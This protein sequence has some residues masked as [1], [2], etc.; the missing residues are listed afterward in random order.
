MSVS[1]APKPNKA[2]PRGLNFDVEQAAFRRQFRGLLRRY[3]NQFVA[4]AGGRV[5][6]HGRNDEVLAER[7]FAQLG[8][9]N[10]A[11]FLVREK[12]EVY[13]FGSPESVG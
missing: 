12:P 7:M 2:A 9:S 5:V 13:E 6:G 1:I 3:R 4:F 11:I 8:H 10:F